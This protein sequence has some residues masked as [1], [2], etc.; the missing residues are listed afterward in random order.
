MDQKLK[1]K[2]EREEMYE[3]MRK[4]MQDISVGPVRQVNKGP[5]IVDQHYGL[6]DFSAFQSMQG[7]PSSFP[8]Q[9]NNSFFEGTQA[10]PS[11]GHNMA[12][13][14]WQTPMLMV[15]TVT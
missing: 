1:K 9:G 13:P 2:A 3:K 15:T 12:T 5:I 4:F 7:G 11:Y 14:N 10:T 8:T 6:S